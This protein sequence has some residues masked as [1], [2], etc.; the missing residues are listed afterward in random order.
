[1]EGF[2]NLTKL[3]CPSCKG[4]GAIHHNNPALSTRKQCT[5]C[6][7]SGLVDYQT[8]RDYKFNEAKKWK[9]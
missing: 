9:K 5:L 4:K 7:G 1:M 2:E 6:A 3:M 8:Y